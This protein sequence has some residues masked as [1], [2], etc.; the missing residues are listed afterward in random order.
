MGLLM[1]WP[2]HS[3]HTAHMQ[4]VQANEFFSNH[5]RPQLA[6]KI[7]SVSALLPKEDD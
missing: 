7:S 1:I 3:L 2:T 5:G 6:Q 4:D